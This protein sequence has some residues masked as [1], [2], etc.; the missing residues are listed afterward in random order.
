[1]NARTVTT[2]KPRGAKT[3]TRKAAPQA[4]A[5]KKA[6]DK[7]PRKS[8]LDQFGDTV[9]V[10]PLKVASKTFMASLG[11]LSYMQTEIEKQYKEFDRKF[12]KYAR[13]GEV[14]LDQFENRVGDFRKDV[15]KRVEEVRGRV[16]DTFEKAA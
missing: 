13:D 10:P 4:A 14:V 16:R 2:S 9:I 3:R 15:E 7:T 11:L 6:A 12:D 5:R 8:V 1:M